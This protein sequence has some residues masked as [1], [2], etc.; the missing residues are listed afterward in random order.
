[1]QLINFLITAL[2]PLGLLATPAPSPAVVVDESVIEDGATA[3]A[4]TTVARDAGAE[5]FKRTSQICQIIGSSAHVNCR[6]CASTGCTAT[7]YVVQGSY[8]EFT[9]AAN[10]QCVTVGGNT[11][12][13]WDYLPA[14]NCY[15]SAIYTDNQCTV[16]SLGYC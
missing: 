4:G 1:M 10:G 14:G 15:V 8:Y 11:N 2:L 5:I 7:H 13:I 3:L 6:S 9:C 12:C 16:G